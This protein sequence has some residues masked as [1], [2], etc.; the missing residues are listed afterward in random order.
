MPKNFKHTI[1]DITG[2]PFCKNTE[3]RLHLV[4]WKAES[5]DDPDDKPTYLHE[6]QCTSCGRSFWT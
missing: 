2:C 4:L 5:E 3:I 6:H 1:K